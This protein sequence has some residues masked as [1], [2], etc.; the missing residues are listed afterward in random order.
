M[1]PGNIILRSGISSAVN[2]LTHARDC[3]DIILESGDGTEFI[4]FHGDG[5][6]TVRGELVDDN[7]LIY[8][9][10]KEWFLEAA[11]L[12]PEDIS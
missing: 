3:G 4:R 2:P 7:L 9:R 5:R 10:V 8:V 1:K 6:V 12:R 11:I